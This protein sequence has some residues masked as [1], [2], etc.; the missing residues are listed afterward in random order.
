[1]VSRRNLP[2]WTFSLYWRRD[3]KPIWRDPALVA[4][5]GAVTAAKRGD[6]AAAA[7]EIAVKLGVGRHVDAGL[8][9]PGDW[10]SRKPACRPMS[11]RPISNSPIPR[12][13]AASPRCSSAA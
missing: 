11:I 12:A 8:R 2:R 1:M 3:G 13:R 10:L 6:E 5:E 9:G 7:G 4:G